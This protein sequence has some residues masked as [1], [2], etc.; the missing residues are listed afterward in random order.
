MRH[1]AFSIDKTSRK[2]E[3]LLRQV[4]FGISGWDFDIKFCFLIRTQLK[5][6]E[7]GELFCDQ[8]M[9][10]VRGI[11]KGY[12]PGSDETMIGKIYRSSTTGKAAKS[13]ERSVDG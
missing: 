4:V 7:N 13:P 8:E 6:I 11:T 9:K 10:K 12:V 5:I 1:S 2:P 3:N